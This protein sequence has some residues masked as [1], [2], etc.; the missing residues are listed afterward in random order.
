M[1]I[2][3]KDSAPAGQINDQLVLITNDERMPQFPVQ[4]Q[5]EVRPELSITPSLWM[6]GSLNPGEEAKKT[7]VIRNN[8]KKPFK[9]LNIVTEDRNINF[10]AID[11]DAAPKA[12]YTLPLTLIAPQEPGR[13]IKTLRIETDLGTMV[14]PEL[15][16]QY[17][18]KAQKNVNLT[19]DQSGRKTEVNVSKPTSEVATP[20]IRTT[21][22]SGSIMIR[23]GV[24]AK[25]T[26]AKNSATVTD[27]PTAKIAV[28]TT[29]SENFTPTQP[30]SQ[31][32]PTQRRPFFRSR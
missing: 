11:P 5:G 22:D 28:D 10:K 30:A 17:L 15:S 27:D 12:L 1:K 8:N 6:V 16:I 7:L 20:K 9:I 18:V 25:I 2:K 4:V 24:D 13:Q 32:N 14:V 26:E 3:L 29:T 23:N 19:G 21:S 31:A